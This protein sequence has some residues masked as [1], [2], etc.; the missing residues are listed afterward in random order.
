MMA[1]LMLLMSTNSRPSVCR[2]R[3]WRRKKSII[4]VISFTS[5]TT[6]MTACSSVSRI[7]LPILIM[8]LCLAGFAA[9][10]LGMWVRA[11]KVR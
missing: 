3:W 10:V 4:I 6:R 8:I 1:L 7:V 2:R 5:C 11:G 9:G